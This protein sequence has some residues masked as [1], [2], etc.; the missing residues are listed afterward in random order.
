[1]KNITASNLKKLREAAKYAQDEVAVA[2]GVTRSAYSNYESGDREMPFDVL[3]KASNLFGCEM[4]VFFEDNENVD[5]LILASA[6]RLDGMES[7][8]MAEIMN[9]KEIVKSYIKME[10]IEAR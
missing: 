2:I 1:M 5:A 9:F 10:A 8:D 6:F 7:A 4:N 3:E